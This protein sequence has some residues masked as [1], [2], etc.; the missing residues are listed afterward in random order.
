MRGGRRR[1][2]AL[3]A[4]FGAGRG[5]LPREGGC[6]D[7]GAEAKTGRM[8]VIS[9]PDGRA[10]RIEMVRRRIIEESEVGRIDVKITLQERE[11]VV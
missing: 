2:R 1:E 6:N 11:S 3:P 10:C 9:G 4:R 7:F 8:P 5:G